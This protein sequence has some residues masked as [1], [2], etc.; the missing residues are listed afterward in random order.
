[1]KVT[2]PANN[3]TYFVY[4]S[5]WDHS[6]PLWNI[7][8]PNEKKQVNSGYYCLQ[9]LLKLKGWPHML[10]VIDAEKIITYYENRGE[11]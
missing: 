5:G 1:M 11:L 7:R 2:N 9:A 6:S 10:A 8:K 3:K 4:I